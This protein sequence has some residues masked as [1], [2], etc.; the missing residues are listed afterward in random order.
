MTGSA[1][2]RSWILRTWRGAAG[3][4]L[5][6]AVALGSGMVASQAAR[7]QTFT[8]LY[9][10]TGSADGANPYA[11]LLLD[12]AGNLYGTTTVGGSSN[13]G[14]VFEVDTNGTETVLHSF[15]GADGISPYAGVIM[16]AKGN[17]Y[18]TTQNGG[19]GCSGTGCGTVFE[20]TPKAGGWTETVLYKFTGSK[21]D[22]ADPSGTLIQDLKGTLYGTTQIGGTTGVFGTVFRVSKAGT[23]TLLHSFAG[24]PSDGAF[25]YLAGVLMDTKGNLYGDTFEGG[26]TQSGGGAA[27][28]LSK[29]GKLTVRHSFGSFP[30]GFEAMGTLV[31]D[32]LG[33]LYG[34]TYRGGSSGYGSVWKVS[35]KGKE[36]V[37]HSFAGGASDGAW[38]EAGVILDAAGNLYGVTTAGGSGTACGKYACGT[39]FELNTKGVLTVLHS[40]TG[41]DG[42]YPIGGLILDSKGNL[43]GTAVYGGSG[44]AGTVWK[45]T[46]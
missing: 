33:N 25:P 26:D 24:S 23:E 35:K 11:G 42:D 43:Y 14:T 31:M 6:L 3:T 21:T 1:Q 41:A 4:A 34:T 20:L 2:S 29:G 38:P 15:S 7:A 30:D 44:G 16:D 37:L 18:G 17:L 22:G 10:F 39:V 19:T 40:F 32:K 9:N 12:T 28:K 46:P 13:Q 27:Y 8:V 45:L 36:T 5:A